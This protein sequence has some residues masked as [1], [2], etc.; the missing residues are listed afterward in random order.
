MPA[1]SL[2]LILFVR[3][4]TFQ[5]IPDWFYFPPWD[6]KVFSEYFT[7]CS[8]SQTR[9]SRAGVPSAGSRCSAMKIE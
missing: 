5:L 8:G 1:A 6:K 2:F 4:K 7:Y 9:L 3:V